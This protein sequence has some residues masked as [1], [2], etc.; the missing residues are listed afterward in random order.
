MAGLVTETLEVTNRIF[1]WRRG[2]EGTKISF[3]EKLLQRAESEIRINCRLLLSILTSFK[4]QILSKPWLQK[5]LPCKTIP[6][7][8]KDFITKR[9]CD[10]DFVLLERNL[11]KYQKKN[12]YSLS[13]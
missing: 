5:S 2:I 1:I 10:L 6:T 8:G 9:I 12:E 3:K 11:A 13:S 4:R 7:Q